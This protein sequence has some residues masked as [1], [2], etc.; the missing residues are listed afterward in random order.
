MSYC[1]SVQRAPNFVALQ[2]GTDVDNVIL[3]CNNPPTDASNEGNCLQ[4]VVL[5]LCPVDHQCCPRA[6]TELSRVLE[7]RF[8]QVA[9]LMISTKAYNF[10]VKL[11]ICA[12]RDILAV[13]ST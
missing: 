2:A 10:V 1:L 11:C 12:L 6:L 3:R 4:R 7:S 8:T 5:E 13:M 9:T